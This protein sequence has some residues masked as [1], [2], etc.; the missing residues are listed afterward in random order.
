[1]GKRAVIAEAGPA[2]LVAD[3]DP[4]L[5]RLVERRLE[6]AG[7][8]V[9]TARNGAEA[10]D[11]LNESVVVALLDLDMPGPG[12][13]ECLR[14]IAVSFP[15][16]ESIIVTSSS[17]ISDAVQAMK[18]GA[19][20]YLTKP[21]N[22]DELV[23]VV[24]KAAGRYLLRQENRMLRA[25]VATPSTECPYVGS[26]AA[27]K[28]VIDKIERIARLGSSV[29]I[30][31]ESGVGKGLVARLIHDSGP[32][33]PRPFITVSCTALPRDLV[34]SELFGHEKGAFTGAVE[35]RP[36]R[37][38]MADGGTLFLDEIGDMPLDL[39]P[40]LLNFLQERCFQRIG[41]VA[42]IEVDVR[43]IAATHQDLRKL[44]SEK[45][46]REDLFFRLNVLPIHL[47]PLRE[48][49]SDI[50]LLTSYLLKRVAERR[51]EGIFGLAPE[52]L[53]ALVAYRWPGNVRELENVLERATA[54]ADGPRL[55]T[56]D[57]P[58][59]VL[60][61]SDGSQRGRKELAGIPLAELEKI[62]IEQT[63]A[64]CGGNK[65]ATARRLGISE[66]SVYNKIKRFRIDLSGG[67][68]DDNS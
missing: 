55:T 66:K 10:L 11:R 47:S 51:G 48:R 61:N 39:Q 13:M 19:S 37:V 56:A 2:V 3:D 68:R 12:G 63:L 35:R 30:T 36:G 31:G 38:E 46:F 54:F 33:R 26:S 53:K 6:A 64:Q 34:E 49:R 16:I 52:V 41:G 5:V 9:L 65:S 8:Q 62:A 17:D 44:C 67:A 24:G 22:L 7:F 27:T 50:P 21:V 45:R 60:A 40:K 25:A 59:E 15:T 57:L 32:R 4:V 1:M 28:E 58:T 18:S 29:L 20:D 14:R 42:T 43:V 23:E